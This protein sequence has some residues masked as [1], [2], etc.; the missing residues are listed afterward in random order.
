MLPDCCLAYS[1]GECFF[2]NPHIIKNHSN[3]LPEEHQYQRY[4]YLSNNS[5]ENNKEDLSNH[6]S[7]EN[8]GSHSIRK[9]AAS[10]CFSGIILSP[11]IVSICLL[12]GWT[13]SCAKERYLEYE[14]SGDQFVRRL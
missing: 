5:I 14:N 9:V 12:A 8:L 11:S 1:M 6:G 3:I 13:I 10:Y 7:V 2:T 4:N